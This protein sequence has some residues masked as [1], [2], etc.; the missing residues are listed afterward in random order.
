MP[1]AST[2]ALLLGVSKTEAERWIQSGRVVRVE[3]CAVCGRSR[4]VE[5]LK[6]VGETWRCRAV[7][8][9]K[10]RRLD[11]RNRA[12]KEKRLADADS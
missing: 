11:A 10:R 12:K 3:L 4:Q 7:S 5:F 2:V 8:T 6:V 9:C 1:S